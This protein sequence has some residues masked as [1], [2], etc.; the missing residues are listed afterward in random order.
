MTAWSYT[1]QIRDDAAWHDG[2]PVTVDDVLWTHSVA[3]IEAEGSVASLLI[4]SVESIE[5]TGDHA[6]RHFFERAQS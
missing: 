1:L 6:T 5:A 2:S 4:A 3:P